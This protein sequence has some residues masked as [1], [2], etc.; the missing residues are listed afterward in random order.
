MFL[1]FTPGSLLLRED[2]A[3]R[4]GLSSSLYIC[5]SLC[6]FGEQF[7]TSP[8]ARNNKHAMDINRRA[9]LMAVDLG[10]G[11]QGLI[12]L[13]AL[14]NMPPPSAKSPF[15]NHLQKVRTV[16]DDVTEDDMSRAAHNLRQHVIKDDAI[17]D[18]N[19]P[20][21]VTVS[22]D[23][24]WSKRGFTANHGIGIIISMDT[25]EILDRYSLSKVCGSCISRSNW[26]KSSDDY[27]QWYEQHKDICTTN[28]EGSSPSNGNAR[29]QSNVESLDRKT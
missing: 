28:Y 25:G 29:C 23:G 16:V 13:C 17:V 11:R 24:T 6:G 19:E 26:D 3:A 1:S 18:D 5:C 15:Q 7:H 2:P 9:A 21:D 8:Y 12:D 22:F 27:K 4:E 10:V 14:L 20:I